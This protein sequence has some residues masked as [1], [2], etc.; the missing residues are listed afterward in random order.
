MIGR[1]TCPVSEE[2]KA[3]IRRGLD[4]PRFSKFAARHGGMVWATED[5]HDKMALLQSSQVLKRLS[6]GEKEV[7]K[8]LAFEKLAF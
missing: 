1:L 2:N 5:M 6:S 4:L 3:L 8:S 7:A